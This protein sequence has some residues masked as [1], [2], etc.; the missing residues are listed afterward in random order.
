MSRHQVTE[1]LA[2]LQDGD[3][4]AGNRL[5]DL[6]YSEL[7]DVAHRQLAGERRNHTLNTTAL[8]N[9]AY[10]KWAGRPPDITWSGRRHFFAIVARAMRQILI[11]HARTRT[12]DKRGGGVP[13]VTFVDNLPL[14]SGKADELLALDEALSQL[15]TISPRQAQIVEYRFFGGLSI[16]DTADLIG[17][18]V[19]TANRDWTTARLWLKREIDS[20]LHDGG[21]SS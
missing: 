5:F 2:A 6:V 7:R 10:L 20:T 13:V 4:K 3:T 18:S 9:E 8:V 1:L 21:A 15:E 19:A 11:D 17:I 14:R 16:I 12:R